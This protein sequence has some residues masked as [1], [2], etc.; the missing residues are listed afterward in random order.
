MALSPVNVSTYSYYTVLK[1]SERTAGVHAVRKLTFFIF[2]IK[3]Q[4]NIIIIAIIIINYYYAST[5][6]KKKKQRQRRKRTVMRC[7]FVAPNLK[8]IFLTK[9]VRIKPAS[10]RYIVNLQSMHKIISGEHL[11]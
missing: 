6:T 8:P 9:K 1:T 4:K 11:T 3:I 2:L 10:Q 5:S 7:M